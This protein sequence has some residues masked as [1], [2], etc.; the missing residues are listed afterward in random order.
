[1]PSLPWPF[2]P[3]PGI[4]SSQETVDRD[5]AK[6]MSLT[7]IFSSPGHGAMPLRDPDRIR[8]ITAGLS[9]PGQAHC[10]LVQ[11]AIQGAALCPH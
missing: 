1:M 7:S 4:Y 10:I 6:G 11:I 5:M 9:E 2:T 3:T 8:S